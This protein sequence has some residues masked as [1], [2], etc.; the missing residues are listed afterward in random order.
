MRNAKP[1]LNGRFGTKLLGVSLA[2][3]MTSAAALSPSLSHA[4]LIT[5]GNYEPALAADVIRSLGNI[6]PAITVGAPPDSP[7]L[8]VDP[9]VPTSPYSG[10]VSIN[11][12][13]D[14]QSY[15]CS[16]ALVGTRSVLT[17]G[18][19]VDTDGQGHY[20]NLAKPGTDVRVVFNSAGDRNA[21]INATKVAVHPDYQ[22][23]GNCPP[24]VN[25]FCVNDDVAVLTLSSDAPATAKR[26]RIA[27]APVSASTHIYMAGY[28]TSGTGVAGYT[29]AP[30]F[31]AKRTGE[32]YIDLFDKNDEANFTGNDEVW[33]ADFDGN[34]QDT[35][36]TMFSACSPA[37]PNNRESSIGGGDSGGPSFINWNGEPVLVGNNT[38]SGWFD[39]Q[40][41][42]TFGTYFG[43]VL[44]NP[45]LG[46]L[47]S[48]TSDEIV[49]V[50]EP[51]SAA[52]L[53]LGAMM[54]SLARR[55]ART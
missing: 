37:L 25:S 19:C 9:N 20:V 47:R 38:F 13:F 35:F 30:S 48:A 53:V 29:V 46:F 44:L 33:Y 28:G 26:Y 7:A 41:K 2:A 4:A 1:R 31:E 49:L 45:Y 17:A 12:R 6:E 50:P 23:F 11:I 27:G 32:N 51:A 18:H 14:G 42:G 43:G 5:N 52:L 55:R 15:I 40:T 8:H 10:V 24:G 3:I 16:G 54:M 22:G 36:C 21:I 34:G 39:G